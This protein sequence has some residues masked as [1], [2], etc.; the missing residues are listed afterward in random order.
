MNQITIDTYNASAAEY[1]ESTVDFWSNFP[2]TFIKIFAELSG[3]DVLNIGSGP[4]RDAVLIRQTGKE[5]VCVDASEAMVELSKQAGFTSILADFNTLPFAENSFD[6]VWSYTSLL[7]VPKKDVSI[8]LDEII[9]IMKPSGVFAL[10][11]I[12]GDE[13]GYIEKSGLDKPRW[14]SLYQKDEV[15]A[16]C[17]KHGF[18]LVHFETYKPRSREYM[19]FIFRKS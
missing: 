10:G 16:L 8:P 19:N 17:K 13:E 2:E 5:V 4:G 6:A 7:H 12:K 14:F 3:K 1:D 9:R 11:L 15:E 18:E